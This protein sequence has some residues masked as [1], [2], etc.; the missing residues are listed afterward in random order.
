MF[1]LP[2]LLPDPPCLPTQSAL[3][4]L[5]PFLKNQTK[6]HSH[7]HTYTYIHTYIQTDRQTDTDAHIHTMKIK[8]NNKMPKAL[9][10]NTKTKQNE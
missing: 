4:S 9:L 1:S 10:K 7:I 6:L 8:T 2:Q 3:C 5:S